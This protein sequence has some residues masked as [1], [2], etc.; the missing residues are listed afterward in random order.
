MGNKICFYKSW[1]TS[2]SYI[3]R[4]RL[5][6]EEK[7]TLIFRFGVFQI[8]KKLQPADCYK[9]L[10]RVW[11]TK[12]RMMINQMSIAINVLQVDWLKRE[13]ISLFDPVVFHKFI[14]MHPGNYCKNFYLQVRPF[15]HHLIVHLK[16]CGTWKTKMK[17][18]RNSSGPLGTHVWGTW[19]TMNYVFE[20]LFWKSRGCAHQ[21]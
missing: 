19:G 21:I 12:L 5:M 13:S 7:T 4:P 10:E 15:G 9:H 16:Q 11:T 14:Y 2:G 8:W 18:L 17:Y 6:S 20:T 3:S 1:C